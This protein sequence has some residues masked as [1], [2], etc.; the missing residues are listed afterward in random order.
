MHV[1]YTVIFGIVL[2]ILLGIIIFLWI[3]YS[4]LNKDVKLLLNNSSGGNSNA[5]G[6]G[7]SG[8]GGG[9]D[10][11]SSG[12][13]GGSAGTGTGSVLPPS[14]NPTEDATLELSKLTMVPINSSFSA[15]NAVVYP[16]DSTDP[17][18]AADATYLADTTWQTNNYALS[19]RAERM[20]D[21]MSNMLYL[22]ANPPTTTTRRK[23]AVSS[24]TMDTAASIVN[25]FVSDL[26]QFYVEKLNPIT[27]SP[28]ES[29]SIVP[30]TVISGRVLPF[31]SKYLQLM[32]QNSKFHLNAAVVFI[33][34]SVGL[35]PT[36]AANVFEQIPSTFAYIM[37]AYFQSSYPSFTNDS[38]QIAKQNCLKIDQIVDDVNAG[39]PCYNSATPTAKKDFK[40]IHLLDGTYQ[41]AFFTT[42]APIADLYKFGQPLYQFIGYESYCQ[43]VIKNAFKLYCHP[44]ISCA[45]YGLFSNDLLANHMLTNTL[46]PSEYTYGA[47]FSPLGKVLRVANEKYAFF[48]RMIAPN[49]PYMY[50][51]FVENSNCLQ[52][53]VQDLSLRSATTQVPAANEIHPGFI[54]NSTK[55]NE[56]LTATDEF[57]IHYYANASDYAMM[58]Q[59]GTKYYASNSIFQFKSN[60]YT[61]SVTIKYD[62]SVPN[63]LTVFVR[64][65]A[66]NESDM[67][68]LHGE[69]PSITYSA[70]TKP[71]QVTFT[72]DLATGS[73]TSAN[74]TPADWTTNMPSNA[75][76]LSDYIIEIVAPK[77]GNQSDYVVLVENV[78]KVYCVSS[79]CINGQTKQFEFTHNNT[80]YL[81]NFDAATSQYLVTPAE[82]TT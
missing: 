74:T 35:N 32:R 70:N 26:Y 6:N 68:I 75:F 42:L 3:E 21:L 37:A 16:Q 30:Y 81:A 48:Y 61:Y 45:T 53:F 72:Y 54:M 46:N 13:G 49:Q 34:N 33:Q 14:G 60:P 36:I 25:S 7:N 77:V 69:D 79:L 67:F 23:R 78:P 4:A 40:I 56:L 64:L 12:G 51:E 18:W 38:Y 15:L 66:S 62:S 20:Y 58:Y 43:S 44:T 52:Y 29:T 57:N 47:V 39:T 27:I 28:G 76:D 63:T 80:K 59:I 71:I 50:R 24:V 31:I 10:S 17:A 82:I 65:M 11:G 55:P 8:G 22:Q 9:G 1:L 5:G 41:L 19:I 2:T 73:V